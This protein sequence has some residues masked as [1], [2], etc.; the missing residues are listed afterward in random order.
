VAGHYARTSGPP[1]SQGVK[2][3]WVNT[4]DCRKDYYA[5]LGLPE[6]ASSTQ[7]KQAY[8]RLARRYHPDATQDDRKAAER[9][10]EISQA[11][12]VL[13]EKQ[14]RTAYDQACPPGAAGDT[15]AFWAP[16]GRGGAGRPADARVPGGVPFALCDL[17]ADL[18]EALCETAGRGRSAPRPDAEVHAT[19]TVDFAEA[20]FGATVPLLLPFPHPAQAAAAAASAAGD[21]VLLVTAPEGSCRS[22]WCSFACPPEWPMGSACA[23]AATAVTYWSASKSARTRSS[24]AAG[25]I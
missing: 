20:V 15:G 4:K 11:Y 23:S 19:A 16:P 2:G 18:V 25:M 24:G 8:R 14:R 6:D 1:E 10:K 13:S 12:A 22:G 9:F 21:P 5:L 17:V 7:I 3:R